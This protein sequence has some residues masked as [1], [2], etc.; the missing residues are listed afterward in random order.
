MTFAR[1]ARYMVQITPYSLE[2][3]QV[4]K[5][6]YKPVPMSAHR[7]A[8][9]ASRAIIRLI[10]GTDS[11]AIDYLKSVQDD[12]HAIALRY[13]AVETSAPFKAYSARDL[14]QLHK[15]DA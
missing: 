13:H 1:N 2:P 14:E 6:I 8:R 15:G 11:R 9:E 4:G 10:T 7:S 12:P 5:P 3:G